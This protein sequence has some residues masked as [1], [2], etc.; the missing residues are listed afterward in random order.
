ML[1]HI[2]WAID[3]DALRVDGSDGGFNGTILVTSV[4][5][6]LPRLVPREIDLQQVVRLGMLGSGAEAVVWRAQ[7]KDRAGSLPLTVALKEPRQGSGVTRDDIEREA[8]IMV[9]LDHSNVVKLVGVIT[10]PREMPAV[11]LME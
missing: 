6:M 1:S 5:L 8:A 11:L 9:L 4:S 10:H 7:V 3:S 2:Q